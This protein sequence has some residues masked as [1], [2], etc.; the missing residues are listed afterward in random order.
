[1]TQHDI[2]FNDAFEYDLKVG[3]KGENH[4]SRLLRNGKEFY[5]VEVK[6]DQQMDFTHNL[7]LE[8]E[9]RGKP[10]GINRTEA[11]YWYI[12]TKDYRFGFLIETALLQK[13]LEVHESDLT[14]GG[15]DGTSVGYK[16]GLP[17]FMRT[18][19]QYA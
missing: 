13:L 8:I 3:K 11:D 19:L 6:T 10:S 18:I 5:T 15:D 2:F 16:I 9:S 14:T 1:M 7:F 4:F 12:Q 17:Q